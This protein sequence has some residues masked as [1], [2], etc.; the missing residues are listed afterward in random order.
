MARH[1]AKNVGLFASLLGVG[2][3]ET[4][5]GIQVP[6]ANG[7]CFEEV[8]CPACRQSKDDKMFLGLF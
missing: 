8:D 3:V 2:W 5:C 1:K 4:V 6:A 7:D